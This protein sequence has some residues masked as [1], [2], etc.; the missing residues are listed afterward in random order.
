MTRK[1]K[2]A[3]F[4]AIFS[5]QIFSDTFPNCFLEDF[6]PKKATIPISIDASPPTEEANVEITVFSKDTLGKISKYIFGNA[7]AAWVGNKIY[8]PTIMDY[9]EKLE[10]TILR[11][12][13]GSWS[14]IFFWNGIPDDIPNT[15]PDGTKNGQP[16]NLYPQTGN[17]TSEWSPTNVDTYYNMRWDLDIEGL[18][19]VNYG[20]ARYGLSENPVAKA[21]HLAAEWVRYDDGR[22]KF[23]EIGNENA[24]PWEAG[25]Q[26]DTNLNKDSQPEIINGELYGK[27]FKIFADSMRAAAVEL[28]NK[29]YIGGQIIHY[30]ATNSWNVAERDWNEGFFR[31]VGDAADFYVIH[32]YFGND[33]STAQKLLDAAS[34]TVK[35]MI[36]FIYKDINDKGAVPK[37]IALT[38]WNMRSMDGSNDR[39]KISIING[40]QAVIVFC[41]LIKYG[42][43]MSCRWLVANWDTDGMFYYHDNPSYPL[44]N[45]R[46][47]FFYIYYLKKFTGDHALK[48]N[49]NNKNVLAYASTF[50]DGEIGIVIVNKSTINLTAKIMIDSRSVGNL[51]YVYSLTGKADEGEYSQHVFV[52]GYGPTGSY[53]GPIENLEEIPAFAYPASDE[54]KVELP[55]RSVQ[56]ILIEA[57]EGSDIGKCDP[58]TINNGFQLFQNY[59]N[60]F[61]SNTIIP[62]TLKQ[63]SKVS[64]K[65]FNIKG[66]EVASLINNEY[67]NTGKHSITL[68]ASAF[69]NGIYFYKLYIRNQT[70]TKKMILLK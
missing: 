25:W 46:P 69:N 58:S 66:V 40:I 7:I 48:T 50:R 54:I 6:K 56:Y 59:P 38:E 53:W 9:L 34:K 49:S 36:N 51:Y 12:P 39:A 64:L 62:F 43:G 13:G 10:V 45:P 18:I 63:P 61:N 35:D 8:N 23:W 24:G 28:G 67:Y 2:T 42:Y 19:T 20:Y 21:A 57:R 60:P 14:D 30:D 52:N 68:D 22:T 16:I 33:N 26:I 17:G 1:L 3:L 32:N 47:D 15:I 29:I 41:E 44:W 55:P 37:P 70:I 31:E 4:L 65:I 5:S 27:H 11:Y